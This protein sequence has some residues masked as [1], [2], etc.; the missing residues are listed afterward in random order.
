MKSTYMLKNAYLCQKLV[1][2]VDRKQV[3]ERL[4]IPSFVK[5]FRQN[6][7]RINQQIRQDVN[8]F[9]VKKF[10]SKIQ[11]HYI[12]SIK[13]TTSKAVAPLAVNNVLNVLPLDPTA[14]F[15]HLQSM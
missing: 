1:I 9:K 8:F 6:N 2:L 13:N 5:S 11:P 10:T 12:S 3:F 4:S 15:Q 7:E 14:T